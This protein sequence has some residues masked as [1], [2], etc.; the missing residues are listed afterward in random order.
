MAFPLSASVTLGLGVIPLR[1]K[2]GHFVLTTF[3]MGEVIRLDF[4]NW[5]TVVG[6]CT[7]IYDVPSGKL[8]FG[9]TRSILADY[10]CSL[11]PYA[12]IL[13]L[14]VDILPEE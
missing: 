5:Q 1:V 3:A 9:P 13:V 8:G 7:G 11:V 6:R 14:M 2:G 10:G 4:G 12:V